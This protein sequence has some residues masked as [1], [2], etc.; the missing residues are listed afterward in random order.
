[1]Q[2]VIIIGCG[3]I[4]AWIA[5][6]LVKTLGPR[7]WITLIDGDTIEKHNLDRQLFGPRDVGKKKSNALRMQLKEGARC[8]IESITGYL[9]EDLEWLPNAGYKPEDTWIM[10]AA[11][12]HPARANALMLADTMNSHCIIAANNYETS[13]AYYYNPKWVGGDRDPREYYPELLTDK[14]DDPL[15]PP[16]T[17]EVLESSPQLA[18]F[19]MRAA[20]D[21]LWLHRFWSVVLP[22][23]MEEGAL[24]DATTDT[25][26]VLVSSTAGRASVKTIG[27]FNAQ[28]KENEQSS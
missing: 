13:E 17:G 1:M 25:I 24:D 18:L 15:S 5:Q 8:G 6:C 26:P 20:A 12:N 22:E 7:D 14:T 28:T 3:G 10:V 16:C 21:A 27:D 9:G 4:G 11:D 19:N 2:Q 23:L